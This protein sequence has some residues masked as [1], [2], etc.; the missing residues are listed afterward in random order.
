MAEDPKDQ[1][2]T[3]DQDPKDQE[4]LDQEDPDQED[5]E[6]PKEKE[7]PEKAKLIRRRDAALRRA[8]KA[9][10]DAAK[11]REKY[12]ARDQDP[13]VRANRK[14]VA[15]EARV[16]MAAKGITDPADQKTL[17]AYLDLGSVTVSGDGDVDSD[18]IQD[19]LEELVSVVGKLSGGGGR[20]R[21]PRLDTRDRGGEKAKPLDPGSKRRRDMLA[22]R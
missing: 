5:Q 11:L 17:A 4:D 20:T 9:E 19:R 1:D 21:T 2:P 6:D 7:D 14:L 22:G 10:E 13:E 8:Q 15:A 16:V 3:K 12:E 18:T